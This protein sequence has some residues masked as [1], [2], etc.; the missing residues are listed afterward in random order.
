MNNILSLAMPLPTRRTDIYGF[1]GSAGLALASIVLVILGFVAKEFIAGILGFL[2]AW[3]YVSAGVYY[4]N[5]WDR[6]SLVMVADESTLDAQELGQKQFR[7]SRTYGWWM[8]L[9]GLL[10]SLLFG[11]VGYMC[12][13]DLQDYEGIMQVFIMIIGTGLII[14]MVAFII[15]MI[16]VS[17]Y[18]N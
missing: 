5:V 12:L 9:I 17:K 15:G 7:L 8:A 16:R 1:I 3:A 18:V 14:S 4:S 10:P 2:G 6:S 11:G 13:S